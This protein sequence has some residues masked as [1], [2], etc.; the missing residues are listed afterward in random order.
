[1][2]KT[3]SILFLFLISTSFV[4]CQNKEEDYTIL[5]RKANEIVYVNPNQSLKIC[6]RGNT[7]MRLSGKFL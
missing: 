4:F 7:C 6:E 2:L 1:M 5:L 3:G